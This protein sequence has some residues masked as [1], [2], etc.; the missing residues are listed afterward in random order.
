MKMG[1]NV[2]MLIDDIVAV[3]L[4]GASPVAIRT[5]EAILADTEA[6]FDSGASRGHLKMTVQRLGAEVIKSRP[7]NTSLRNA[8]KNT[9]YKIEK[10]DDE[11]D[12]KVL[13]VIRGN[14]A[15]FTETVNTAADRIAK[16]G[17]NI[18]RDGT[19]ILTGSYSSMVKGILDTAYNVLGKDIQVYVTETRPR[20]QGVKMV[21]ELLNLG[22]PTT[23][24]VDSSARH[25]MKDVD[26][27]IVGAD[28]VSSDGSAISKIGASL[29]ALAAHEA[30]V[31]LYA[32]AET[33]KFSPMTMFGDAVT[34]EE[35][36]ISEVVR[37]GEVRDSVKIFN[38]VFDST[39][40]AY[41]DAI[42]TELG[43]M[44]PGSVYDVMV[45]QLGD[46]IFSRERFRWRAILTFTSGSPRIR[47]GTSFA[48][49]GSP[50]TF[51]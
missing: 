44:S 22:I 50:P 51:R 17:A 26:L 30:R 29:I 8:V 25:L 34:I 10:I 38:P 45:R 31:H 46:G 6:E 43:M 41:I 36:D 1:K 37:P 2:D 48:D 7:T 42:V 35:R 47:T 3:R 28:T 16:L 11:D 14:V 20:Y 49:T 21:R 39:P 33:Y 23:L 9:L 24:I 32:C 4:K 40:A 5:A 15:A 18:L 13:E 19:T 27:V 12:E